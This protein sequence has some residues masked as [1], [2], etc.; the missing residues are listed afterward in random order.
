MGKAELKLKVALFLFTMVMLVIGFNQM[1]FEHIP[2]AFNSP[3]EDMSF[4]WFVPLVS[5]YMLYR[6]RNK[7]FEN[8]SEAS[9]K[10]LLLSLP[11]F[12]IG[13]FGARGSQLRLEEVGFVGLLISLTWGFWGKDTAKSVFFPAIYLLFCMPLAT[14]LDVITVH[15]RL[16]VTSTAEF[17]INGFGISVDRVGTMMQLSNGFQIDVAN[18]CSGLRSIFAI[19]ALATAYGYL[20]QPTWSR[21]ITL[22]MASIPLAIIGNIMRIL[23][24]CFAGE[25]L[26]E[27][28]AMGVVHDYSGFVV[29]LVAIVLMLG[30]DSLLNHMGEGK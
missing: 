15:L 8:L 3:E 7:I 14:F 30:I 26:S 1:I 16:F 10:G 13:F 17:I 11:F 29:F 2:W 9:Y 4:G 23:S 22:F 19:M 12:I 27:D 5:A 6:E 25:F 24:I 18:P 28:A 21:R 20:S